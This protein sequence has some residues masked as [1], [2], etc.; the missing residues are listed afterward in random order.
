[1]LK[2]WWNAIS[3]PLTREDQAMSTKT[4]RQSSPARLASKRRL[5][6]RKY[7]LHLVLISQLHTL[8]VQVTRRLPL[9]PHQFQLPPRIRASLA[10][11][12]Q[13]LL[14]S[15][16]ASQ[17]YHQHRRQTARWQVARSPYPR[18]SPLMRAGTPAYIPETYQSTSRDQAQTKLPPSRRMA[19]R[20]SKHLLRL[21]PV[22]T[23]RHLHT[24]ILIEDTIVLLHNL[25]LFL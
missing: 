3:D 6:G 18:G 12:T 21:C 20:K 8:P 10:S 15:G 4:F 25:Q 11:T 13:L 2:G 5:Q 23:L 14:H 19:R 17:S 22:H 24:A 9:H 7:S 16:A 1:M